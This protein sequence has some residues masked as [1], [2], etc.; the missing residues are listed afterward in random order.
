MGGG[1][2]LLYYTL[3]LFNIF[4]GLHNKYVYHLTLYELQ[5]AD[6]STA[7]GLYTSMIIVNIVN[8]SV[9]I[10]KSEFCDK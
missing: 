8:F 2:Q 5:L 3:I 9:I 7:V 4:P 10:R 6:E 1:T